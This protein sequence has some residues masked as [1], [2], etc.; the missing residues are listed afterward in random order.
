MENNSLVITTNKVASALNLQTIKKYIK[1]SYSIETNHVKSPRLPQ[2]KSFLKIIS[3]PYISESTNL[4][5][6]S[7][8]V[9][10]YYQDQLHIQ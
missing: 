3:I 9:E 10:K 6:T 7:D 8:E 1:N 4:H 2:S 5:I